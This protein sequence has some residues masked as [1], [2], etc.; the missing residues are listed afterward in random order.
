[1]LII[2]HILGCFSSRTNPGVFLNYLNVSKEDVEGSQVMEVDE[3]SSESTLT[4]PT[5][6]EKS[7]ESPNKEATPP[8]PAHVS[9][10]LS[11]Q[12]LLLGHEALGG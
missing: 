12:F 2:Q 8:K 9:L 11:L 7:E 3:Q 6:S 1:V 5:E 10:P 4:K